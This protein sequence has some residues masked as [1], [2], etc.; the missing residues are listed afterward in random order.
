MHPP[1]GPHKIGQNRQVAV[2]AELMK[3]V[4]LRPGDAVYLQASPD[5]EGTLM[6]IPVELATKWFETGRRASDRAV[7]E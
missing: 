4:D 5:T 1:H 2:P 3:A 7:N 6:I